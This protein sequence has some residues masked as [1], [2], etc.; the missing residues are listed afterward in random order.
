MAKTL[1][2]I[3][4][5][6]YQ[7]PGII[8][9]KKMGLTV[10]ATDY[11]P[12]AI[13]FEYCDIFHIIDVKDKEENL[14]IAKK[15][16]IN[17]VVSFATEIA[18]PTVAYIAEQLNL[19][20]ID[21][22]TS[23]NATNKL[24]M[25][26]IFKK[27]NIPSVEFFE[28]NSLKSLFDAI[29]I[30][31]FPAVLKPSDSSGSRG[32]TVL[33]SIG[34]VPDSF[35]RAISY[36]NSKSKECILEE[37]FE[38]IECTIEGFSYK[39]N[40]S[41]LA[42]SEKKKPDTKYRVATELFYPPTF[43]GEIIEKIKSTVTSAL[44]ALGIENGMT[45]S[46]IIV[47]EEGNL[48]IVEVAARGGGFGISNIIIEQITGFDPISSLI[49]LSIGEEIKV[50]IKSHNSA[51]LK[52]YAPNPGILEEIQ[53]RE[54]LKSI[55]N[56]T[57]EFFIYESEIIPTLM[58]DGSRT[59]SIIS[60]GKNR[61]QVNF[62][63]KQV[64]D[65]INFKISPFPLPKD[66]FKKISDSKSMNIGTKVKELRKNNIDIVDLS[67]GEPY[68]NTPTKIIEAAHRFLDSGYTHYTPGRGYLSLRTAL[69]N[70]IKGRLNIDYDPE[71]EIILTNGGKMGSFYALSAFIQ[72][73]DEVLILEPFWL[74]YKEQVLLAGGKPIFVKS[75]PDNIFRPNIKDLYSKISYK[76]KILILNNP[77]NPTGIVF[78]QDEL[79]K[80]SK[81]VIEK[82]LLIISD[83][84]Y[85]TITFDRKHISISQLENMRNRT[86]IV[87]SF[88]KSFAMTGW[89]IGVIYAPNH[90]MDEIYKIHQHSSTCVVDFIQ[91]SALI[92]LNEC[93]KEPI[94][95]CKQYK[96]KRDF[97]IK[98]STEL[99]NIELIK[100][101]GT[102]Y[103][104]LKLPNSKYADTLISAILL[105]EYNVATVPGSAYGESSTGY[106]RLCFAKPEEELSKG[107]ERISKFLK[108]YK[109]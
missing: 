109:I 103:A 55:P 28:I 33:H 62:Q 76:S 36:G 87:D 13:G 71:K 101:E 19:P 100:P 22:E 96:E 31:G 1:L 98:R 42:I 17:G 65:T 53:G 78:T 85:R 64:E 4:A 58:T 30:I 104:M 14:K 43:R 73:N 7:L 5:G 66:S 59:A 12:K 54:K 74:S 18:V 51:I 26:E 27:A 9:A 48:I 99:G 83:E 50:D 72:N 95:M 92:A 40:H 23:L 41:I 80:I 57:V 3:G 102:F 106:L 32:V 25:R 107:L 84:V 70:E 60:W 11:D 10:I 97:L 79:Q 38:G 16:R 37:F 45:H 68:F 39:G 6:K 8:K 105:E 86:I 29:N 2:V 21:Y 34:E 69:C 88:S 61:E 93:I 67:W 49:M 75:D 56:T 46:E 81:L 20:G 82:N 90:L 35:N 52:F 89:R 47:N 94:H 44:D 108:K 91:M 63:V 24:R 77:C 15:Y